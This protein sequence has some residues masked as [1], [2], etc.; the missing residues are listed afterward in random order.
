MCGA[1]HCKKLKLPIVL[2]YAIAFGLN[3]LVRLK[4]VELL[5]RNIRLGMINIR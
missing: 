5:S 2:M 4:N 1:T 3:L